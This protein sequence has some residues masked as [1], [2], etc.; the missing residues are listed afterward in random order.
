MRGKCWVW[1]GAGFL[2]RA[3]GEALF[4]I[5]C[6]LY[7][8]FLFHFII[9]PG[10]ASIFRDSCKKCFAWIKLLR[11][12][13]M[14]M[15]GLLWICLCGVCS[16]HQICALLDSVLSQQ[17]LVDLFIQILAPEYVSVLLQRWVMCL[18]V[19]SHLT[20]LQQIFFSFY[21]LLETPS[22]IPCTSTVDLDWYAKCLLDTP[23]MKFTSLTLCA[24]RKHTLVWI[25]PDT[26]GI[27]CL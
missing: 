5:I 2:V 4:G 13:L 24:E 8:S 21:H 14:L 16:V 19:T 22:H 20:Q 23:M 6:V 17:W 1:N 25:G 18:R 15:V 27:S 9:G 10:P 3:R 12:I 26:Q 11:W 7:D